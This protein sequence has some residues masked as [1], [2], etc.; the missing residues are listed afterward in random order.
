MGVR[1]IALARRMRLFGTSLSGSG[2][3]VMPILHGQ[4]SGYAALYI[5]S[6]LVLLR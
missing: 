1:K 5:F 2:R 4:H 3:K 6:V